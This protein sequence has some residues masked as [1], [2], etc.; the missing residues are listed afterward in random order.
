MNFIQVYVKIQE[1]GRIMIKENIAMDNGNLP[2]V[3]FNRE[4]LENIG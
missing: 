2:V 1:V 3:L 4:E